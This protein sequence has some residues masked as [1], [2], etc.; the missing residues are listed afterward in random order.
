MPAKEVKSLRQSTGAPLMECKKALEK[1]LGDHSQATQYLRERQFIAAGKKE[2]NESTVGVY[3]IKC[4]ITRK[5][6]LLTKVT[7]ETDFVAKNKD[8]LQF[9]QNLL[10]LLNKDIAYNLN[11]ANITQFL[12]ENKYNNENT[13]LEAQKTL[14]A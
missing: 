6:V 11:K 8:F 2:G 10:N 5:N 1:F 14:T 3:G 9:C 7:S 4:P 13:I 12:E